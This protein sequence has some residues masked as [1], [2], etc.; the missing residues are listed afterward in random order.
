M[1]QQNNTPMRDVGRYCKYGTQQNQQS[2]AL[3]LT[4]NFPVP[5]HVAATYR[6][7]QEVTYMNITLMV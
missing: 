2:P 3:T 5:P 6:R 4:T 1:V 7:H